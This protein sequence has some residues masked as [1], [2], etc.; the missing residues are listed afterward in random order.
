[1]REGVGSAHKQL[2]VN[3]FLRFGRNVLLIDL[4]MA[5]VA[6]GLSIWQGWTSLE[7]WTA[8]IFGGGAVLLVLAILPTMGPVLNTVSPALPGRVGGYD[9][10]LEVLGAA[11]RG[12][13]FARITATLLVAGFIPVLFAGLVAWRFL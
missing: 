5:A 11:E 13:A 1:M 10:R 12:P 9:P 4:A 2:A 8:V 6:L 7:E 3:G